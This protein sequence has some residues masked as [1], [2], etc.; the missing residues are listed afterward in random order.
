MT[1]IQLPR[2]SGGDVVD[3]IVADHRVFE[4]LLRELR[5][6]TADRESARSALANLLIA[7]SEAEES[8]VYSK[9]VRKD[10]IEQDDAEHGE[11]EH[12]EGNEKLLALLECKAIDTAKFDTA[13]EELATSLTHHFGEEELTILNPARIDVD[14]ATRGRLGA[15]WARV[16]AD[17]LD[18]GAGDIDYVRNLVGQA[19]REGKLDEPAD[20]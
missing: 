18:A 1:L 15:A 6:A 20:A 12:A 3:L 8:E 16:R 19:R 9:L 5:D 14:D 2:P 10:A 11:H 7:H 17:R 13:V 4:A